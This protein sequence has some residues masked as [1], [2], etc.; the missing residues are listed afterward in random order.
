MSPQSAIMSHTFC[1]YGN[2][3]DVAEQHC[4]CRRTGSTLF[5]TKEKKGTHKKRLP[6]RISSMSQSSRWYSPVCHI[7]VL[8]VRCG[9][10]AFLLVPIGVMTH[11]CPTRSVCVCVCVWVSE[12]VC[13]CVCA[14]VRSCVCVCVCVCV[15]MQVAFVIH[16]GLFWNGYRSLLIYKNTK[17]KRLKSAPRHATH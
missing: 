6:A 15:Y 3:L 7:A 13:V 14:C 11:D 4:W 1:C 17:L 12:W 9:D 5:I 8:S 16:I 2:F 10:P